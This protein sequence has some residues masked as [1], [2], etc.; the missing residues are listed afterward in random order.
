MA[1]RTVEP[2]RVSTARMVRLGCRPFSGD[3]FL[4]QQDS[5]STLLAADTRHRRDVPHPRGDLAFVEIVYALQIHTSCRPAHPHRRH[6]RYR[7]KH[8]AIDEHELDVAGFWP[9]FLPEE[10]ELMWTPVWCGHLSRSV[11]GSFEV[12]PKGVEAIRLLNRS[13]SEEGSDR[14]R[15]TRVGRAAGSVPVSQAPPSCRNTVGTALAGTAV[16]T[17]VR[18]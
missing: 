11:G 5:G 12:T 18:R 6:R 8:R 17:A 4:R 16:A 2:M 7:F 13:T 14:D 10:L 1:D 15:L 3:H 9:S